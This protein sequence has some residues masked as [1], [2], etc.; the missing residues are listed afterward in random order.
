MGF[1][2]DISGKTGAEAAKAAA[3]DTYGKQQAATGELKAYGDQYKTAFDDLAGG[4]DP[5]VK[6]GGSALE[7]LMAGLGLGGD[8]AGFADAYRSL[9]G[10]QAGLETGSNAVTGNSAAKGMLN[11]GATL[12]ALQRYGSDY[13]D[14]RVGSYL[15]RLMGLSNTGQTATGQ[16][17]ATQGQ[18]LQGQLATRQSAYGGDM[19]A[20][21]TI[22]QGDIAA[23][24]ARAAGA[25]NILGAGMK[26]G[27]M[28]L[29][30]MTGNP[31][32][33]MGGASSA[34]QYPMGASNAPNYPNPYG[35][36]WYS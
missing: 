4:Y 31:M 24:N 25:N 2:Q 34:S 35:G 10:Y 3:A 16:Q 6:A 19:T 26:I 30:A 36:S 27:G 17:I 12:K 33:A 20:A 28:A 15:D 7:R 14:Q 13:E 22:G 1:F 11:S 8:T 21:G 32:A 9:P 18:G 5:Y 23:A 29:G